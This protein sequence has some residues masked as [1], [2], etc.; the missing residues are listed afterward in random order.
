MTLNALTEGAAR[1]YISSSTFLWHQEFEL[2]PGVFT[3]GR[4][5]VNRL[6]EKAQLP[7][8]TGL[9]VLDIGT[10]NGGLAFTL[11]RLGAHVV[12]VDMYPPDVLG[13]AQTRD[14]LSSSVDYVQASVYDLASALDNERFDLAFFWG[15]IYHLRHPLLS[16]DNVHA[17]LRENGTAYI[18]SAVSDDDLG[19]L[20]A[21]PVARFYRRD[22][23]GGDT[24]NWFAPSTVCLQEW[25][26]SSGLAP[27][28]TETWASRA[29]VTVR[30]S[31]PEFSTL[32]SEVALRGVPR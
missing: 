12:A 18:E 2:V 9:S 27:V 22:E 13:F 30:R 19:D 29:M 14:F 1:E 7:A 24:T 4:N 26:A 28:A 15:V 21:F 17:V 5:P 11:E 25:C 23:L 16:L 31:E 10:F 32:S 20:A 6:L 3:P 8:V